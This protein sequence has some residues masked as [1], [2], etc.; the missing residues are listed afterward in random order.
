M[1]KI[2]RREQKTRKE[3]NHHLCWQ[4]RFWNKGWAR[5]LRNHPYCQAIIPRD[6]LHK[7]IHHV[8]GTIPVPDG[9]DARNVYELLIWLENHE[10]L[11]CEDDILQKLDFLI[12]HLTTEATV[13]AL[14]N[15]RQVIIDFYERG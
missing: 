13:K 3:D 10:R 7:R 2:I 11:N 15:Q 5:A 14:E 12:E 1:K 9:K 6:T 4:R 8:I